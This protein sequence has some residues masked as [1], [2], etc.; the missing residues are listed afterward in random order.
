MQKIHPMLWFD[1]QAEEAA[2]LYVSI[3]K[4]S[5]IN[6]VSRYP[7][8]GPAPEGRAMTVSFELEGKQFTALNAGPHFKFNEAVS[9]VVDCKS[10]DEVDHYWTKLTKDGGQ[11]SQCGWLKD[12]YGL[13]WQITPTAL[14]ELVTSS[15]PAK[16]GRAMAA[17]MQMTKIDIAKIKEAAAG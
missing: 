15:D 5:K 16:A 8:G 11:P 9:F 7:A 3:F 13:S 14:I 2:N 10:Q 1:T 12:K 17:M 4:N 6:H